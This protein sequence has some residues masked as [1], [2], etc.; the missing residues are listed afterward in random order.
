MRQTVAKRLRRE[1]YGEDFSHRER[2]WSFA[3]GVK[4]IKGKLFGFGTHKDTGR[5]AEY[6]RLKKQYKGGT[7]GKGTARSKF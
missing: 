7:Y 3:E 2:K 5:R 1:V 4:N 6:Q